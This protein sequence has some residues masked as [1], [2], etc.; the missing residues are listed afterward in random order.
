MMHERKRRIAVLGASGTVGRRIVERLLERGSDVVSQT[1]SAEKLAHLAGRAA[2]HTFDPR[3]ADRLSQFITGADAVIFA[4]GIDTMGATTM[5]SETTAALIKAMQK[6]NVSRLIAITGV[7]A[8]ETQGHGGLLYDWIIFPLFTRNRYRDKNKQ[9]ELIVASDLDWTIVRPAPFT[10]KPVASE[11]QVLTKIE[12][13][14]R[15]SRITR[16]E[17]ADFVVAQ[18]D[19]EQFVRQRPFVGHS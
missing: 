12:P 17:V 9:E 3:D 8:G 5:F 11:L 6:H 13:G 1:R 18:L 7:G 16:D 14:T 10:D 4:L 19:S 15:L 2:V